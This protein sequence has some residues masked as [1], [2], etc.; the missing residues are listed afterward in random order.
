MRFSR[1]EREQTQKNWRMWKKGKQW[2]CG[3]ALFFTVVSSPGM[4][5]LADE[6]NAGDATEVTVGEEASPLP[7]GSTENEVEETTEEDE[8]SS[9]DDAT[10]TQQEGNTSNTTENVNG[11]KKERPKQGRIITSPTA[12]S[13][14]FPDANLAEAIR[15][16]LGKTSVSDTVTQS[17]LDSITSLYTTGNKNIADI[18]GMENLTKLQVVDLS[19]NQ[20][21]DV[22]TLAS[23]VNL[24]GLNLQNNPQLNIASVNGLTRLVNLDLSNNPQLNDVSLSNMP[25]LKTFSMEDTFNNISGGSLRLSNMPKLTT[26]K[27]FKAQ[28]AELSISDVPEL[29]SLTIQN[30]YLFQEDGSLSLSNIPKLTTLDLSVQ[31]L[32]EINVSNL[33]SLTVL[34]AE[35]NHFSN[36]S[37]GNMSS[38]STLVLRDNQLSDISNI[39]DLPN[40]KILDLNNNQLSNIDN[41]QSFPNLEKLFLSE[42]QLRELSGVLGIPS[43]KSLEATDNQLSDVSDISISSMPNLSFVNLNNNHISD[44]SSLVGFLDNTEQ[45]YGGVLVDNQSIV[46]PE[47]NWSSSLEI[48]VTE[49]NGQNATNVSNISNDGQFADGAITWTNL[50]NAEQELDYSWS[51]R[52]QNGNSNNGG[53]VSHSGKTTVRV[54]PVAVKILVDSDGDSQT[55]GDQTLLAEESD[56]TWN[57]LEDMYNYAK[58]QLNGTD[59]GLIS[60][61]PNSDGDYVILVSKVGSLK[62]EDASGTAVGTDVPYTPTYTVTGTGDDAELVVSYDEVVIDAPPAGYVYIYEKGTTQEVRYTADTS[63]AIPLTDTNGNGIPQWKE[64]YTVKQYKKAGALHPSIPGGDLEVIGVPDDAV[65]GDIVTIPPDTIT[66]SDGREYIVDPSID[67]DPNTPG[68]QIT[69]T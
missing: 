36:V 42:N 31:N 23:L 67:I 12:I 40:L 44:V 14:V 34:N 26:L 4:L 3:A 69:L 25:E 56:D 13:T 18:S 5:V 50:A 19:G 20:V 6:V 59:Y 64:D 10:P 28:F 54:T 43:L 30:Q 68:V 15:A 62:K 55:T 52:Y 32:S 51:S 46:L 38:L 37:I 17:D 21:S 29:S 1:K 39:S 8:T 2:L 58:D 16:K 27:L 9:T 48:P 22:S 57:S 53:S 35:R 47:I 45:Y 63:I 24:M 61:A 65:G 7:E 49:T 66:G 41:I 60:I 33:S 11:G